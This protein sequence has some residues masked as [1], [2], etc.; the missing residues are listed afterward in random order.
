MHNGSNPCEPTMEDLEEYTTLRDVDVISQDYDVRI[1]LDRRGNLLG[2][3]VMDE[4]KVYGMDRLSMY[5]KKQILNALIEVRAEV[6]K[7]I[8]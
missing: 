3:K 8:R 2:Y 4:D 1:S 7:T 5:N 6:I